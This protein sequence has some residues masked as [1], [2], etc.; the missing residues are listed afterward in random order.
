MTWQEF[1]EEL[2]TLSQKIDFTPDIIVGIVRGGL[3]PAR[4][5][6][7]SL[8][9]K[10]MYCLTVKKVGE[11]RKVMSEIKEDFNNK[12]ILLVEDMLETGRSLKVAED[13]LLNKGAN[14][15]T[16]CFYVMSISEIKPDFYLKEVEVLP[17]FPWE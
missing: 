13:Y 16:V 6:S 4:L 7:K 8:K 15:K 5:L 1:E 17:V 12:N 2:N 11:E 3:V 9:V 10:D 14:V